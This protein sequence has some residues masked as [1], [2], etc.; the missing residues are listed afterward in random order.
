MGCG[1]ARGVTDELHTGES[2]SLSAGLFPSLLLCHPPCASP[3]ASASSEPALHPAR[4][5]PDVSWTRTR[6]GEP[7]ELRAPPAS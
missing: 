3:G 7:G 6:A 5:Q 4:R 2:R 1:L